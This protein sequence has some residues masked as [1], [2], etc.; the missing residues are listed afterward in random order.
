VFGDGI[1]PLARPTQCSWYSA[2][3]DAVDASTHLR[4][5]SVYF[6][7]QACGQQAAVSCSHGRSLVQRGADLKHAS[8]A[9]PGVSL[10]CEQA[11]S[12][13]EHAA[14]TVVGLRLLTNTGTGLPEASCG[15]DSGSTFGGSSTTTS[16]SGGSQ[17]PQSFALP[18][19]AAF[20]AGAGAL[21]A[22]GFA[23]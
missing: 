6:S 10:L 17:L 19:D 11:E 23:A 12:I 18:S 14:A 3:Y 7:Q 5:R 1:A 9:W 15:R 8:T 4:R 22:A 16:S 20:A 21:T 2:R 13:A